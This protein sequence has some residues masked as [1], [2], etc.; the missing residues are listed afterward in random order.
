M[1]VGEAFDWG[2]VSEDYA[3]YR[4]VYP[5]M[6][7][8]KLVELSLGI[9]GQKVLDLGTGVIPKNMYQYGAIG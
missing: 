5:K 9:S 1:E 8:E 4:D 6:F 3:K 7:Y 2:R